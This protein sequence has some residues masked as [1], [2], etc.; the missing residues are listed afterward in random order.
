YLHNGLVRFGGRM[1][2]NG[3]RVEAVCTQRT[4]LAKLCNQIL[5]FPV[6]TSDGVDAVTQFIIHNWSRIY[7]ADSTKPS[8]GNSLVFMDEILTEKKNLLQKAFEATD[9][10]QSDM[11]S[12]WIRELLYL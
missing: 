1:I 2:V 10:T 9:E 7:D 8:R 5:N 11:E 6:G 3:N 12:Q 4:D